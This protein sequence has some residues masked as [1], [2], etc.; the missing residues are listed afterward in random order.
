MSTLYKKNI[1]VLVIEPALQRPSFDRP[2]PNGNLG[3]AYIIAALRRHGV[4]VDYLDATV[5][6][7]GRDL[8]ETFY[9][10]TKLENGLIRFG[11]SSEEFPEIFSNYDIIAT[12]SI[13][14]AQTRMHFEIA[15]IAKKV[16]KKNGK[17]ILTI[18]GGVNA[19]ALREHFL[20]NG[21]DIVALGEGE[22]T[23][24]QLASGLSPNLV[25]GLVYWKDGKPKRSEPNIKKLIE[26]KKLYTTKIG[27]QSRDFQIDIDDFGS[28]VVP[29]FVMEVNW[30]GLLLTYSG[31][32]IVF[33]LI[34]F[35]IIWFVSRISLQRI[36]RLGD[37]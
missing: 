22:R 14:S 2:R 17:K 23:M 27:D 7:D 9:N 13:F 6:Q 4:D 19:R 10:K 25:E 30:S 26:T 28:Q 20:S 31:M 24:D 21:F 35:G 8:N 32:I 12:S 29:P 3:P 37:T 33:W 15:T 11:M 5:G 18:A 34:T 16:S 1:R 36:L